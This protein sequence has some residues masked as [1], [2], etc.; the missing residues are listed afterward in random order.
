MF[1]D[2][3]VRIKRLKELNNSAVITNQVLAQCHNKITIIFI[4][5][6]EE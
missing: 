3:N 5:P 1:S 4:H 2:V 6:I